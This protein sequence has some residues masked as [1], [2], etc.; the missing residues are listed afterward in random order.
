MLENILVSKDIY[1]SSTG[2]NI[3]INMNIQDFIDKIVI[4]PYA[5]NYYLSTLKNTVE[6]FGLNELV[7]KISKSAIK[8]EQ[9]ILLN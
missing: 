4:S 9:E 8:T 1:N 2:R 3:K 6:R 7:S 5:P